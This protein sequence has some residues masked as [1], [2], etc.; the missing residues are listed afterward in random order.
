MQ[1]KS[2]DCTVVTTNKLTPSCNASWVASL[3]LSFMY[4]SWARA[5][6]R[7]I[8]CSESPAELPACLRLSGDTISLSCKQERERFINVSLFLQRKD[9]LTRDHTLNHT[10]LDSS[11]RCEG[12]SSLAATKTL[13]GNRDPF[14]NKTWNTFC[15]SIHNSLDIAYRLNY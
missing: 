15:I 7:S 8:S 13:C 2:I 5:N 12:H 4:C 1:L 11:S 9:E 14:S 10:C 3:S 6:N